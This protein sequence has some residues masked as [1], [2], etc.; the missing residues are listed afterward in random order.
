MTESRERLYA[1]ALEVFNARGINAASIHEICAQAQVS[2]GSAYHHFGSKQGLADQLLLDGLNQHL[3]KLEQA[4]P[5]ARTPKSRVAALINTLI[6]WI[7]SHPAWARYIYAVADQLE[8]APELTEQRAQINQR[9]SACLA[10]HFGADL[11]AGRL[12]RWPSELMASIVIGPVHDYA[13]R[14]L[15][16][17]VASKPS[18]YRKQFV[19][20]AWKQLKP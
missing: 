15:A 20:A 13:R 9:Y 19:D 1:A 12:R 8:R 16:G 5:S 18:R 11:A 2:I 4:L 6:D 7:E 3:Q 17:Q 14:Y 10:Q